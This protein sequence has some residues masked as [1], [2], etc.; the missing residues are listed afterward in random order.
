MRLGKLSLMG[1]LAAG[2]ILSTGSAFA[3]SVS[4]IAN[5]AGTV[6]VTENSIDFTGSNFRAGSSAETGSFLG[7]TGGTV[8]TVLTGGPTT[9][10][11]DY[12]KFMT[13]NVPGANIDFDLTYIAPGVGTEAACGSNALGQSCTIA[14]SP[15]TLR[16]DSL[17]PNAVDITLLLQ[18][19]SYFTNDQNNTSPTAGLFTTQLTNTIVVDDATVTGILATLAAGGSISGASY[20]ATFSASPTPEP[21]S[22]L[23][24]SVGLLGAG[25]IGRRK[26]QAAKLN[27]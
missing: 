15:F 16:Q 25:Y 5:I 1:L 4:G 12:A 24:M 20:S 7:L 23:L 3:D 8:H 18:G 19:V 14:N 6:T 27:A 11:V 2:S 13:F 17:N 22:L 10:A 21:A 26:A 9:G